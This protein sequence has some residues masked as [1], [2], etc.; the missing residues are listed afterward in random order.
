MSCTS[1]FDRCFVR[2]CLCTFAW[3]ALVRVR[4]FPGLPRNR[5]H[6]CACHVTD[7]L[8]DTC[9]D[10][11]LDHAYP[12]CSRS[13]CTVRCVFSGR[14]ESA[15]CTAGYVCPRSRTHVGGEF[16]KRHAHTW[17]VGGGSARVLVRSWSAGR[18]C[19]TVARD[20]R[21]NGHMGG[22]SRLWRRG[23]SPRWSP[24]G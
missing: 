3:D 10:V 24:A 12:T 18:G 14:V 1:A 9:S 19:G 4:C 16:R 8:T 6:V 15:A 17:S 21:A 20:G 22:R 2:W 7:T 11:Y 5:G 23:L 13:V